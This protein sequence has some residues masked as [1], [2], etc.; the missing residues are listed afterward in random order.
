MHRFFT[1][2]KL[3]LIRKHLHLYAT[4]GFSMCVISIV[5]LLDHEQK[6]LKMKQLADTLKKTYIFYFYYI[7]A[8]FSFPPSLDVFTVQLTAGRAPTWHDLSNPSKI[9]R[10]NRPYC[11]FVPSIVLGS[12]LWRHKNNWEFDV[13]LCQNLFCFTR[14]VEKFLLRIWEANCSEGRHSAGSFQR[15]G[16]IWVIYLLILVFFRMNECGCLRVNYCSYARRFSLI[17]QKNTEPEKTRTLAVCVCAYVSVCLFMSVCVYERRAPS[18]VWTDASS[19]VI[20]FQYAWDRCCQGQQDA[21]DHTYIGFWIWF[22][23]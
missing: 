7:P 5:P 10:I 16:S 12:H 3:G 9:F 13:L 11:L 21:L 1:I 22:S 17:R 19:E 6:C 2:L 23:N 20:L 14:L 18:V 8:L 4:D 15:N